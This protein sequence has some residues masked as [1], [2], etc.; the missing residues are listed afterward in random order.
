MLKNF[1]TLR[2]S[3]KLIPQFKGSY[4]IIKYLRND[5]YI[6]LDEERHFN[7]YKVIKMFNDKIRLWQGE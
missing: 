7:T 6:V 3:K 5:R 1:D 4:S 2:V